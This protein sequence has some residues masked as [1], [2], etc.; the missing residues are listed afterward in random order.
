MMVWGEGSA[1]QPSSIK[2]AE[3]GANSPAAHTNT[4][5]VL[6]TMWQGQTTTRL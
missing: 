5:C 3:G 4:R 6:V 2:G 1:D